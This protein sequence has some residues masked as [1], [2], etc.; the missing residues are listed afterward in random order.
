[1]A[2][3]ETFWWLG[4][5]ITWHP[6]EGSLSTGYRKYKSYFGTTPV[7]CVAA[8][9]NFDSVRPPKSEPK[10]LLWAL[11]HLKLYCTEHVDTTLVGVTE[12]NFENGATFLFVFLQKGQW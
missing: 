9:D 7:V 2:T 3:P 10:H 5:K 1:M 12:K 6:E 11:L 4:G 8:W